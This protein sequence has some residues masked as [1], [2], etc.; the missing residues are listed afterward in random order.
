MNKLR[1][2]RR[3]SNVRR[4]QR[5]NLL[6]ISQVVQIQDSRLNQRCIVVYLT[7][8]FTLRQEDTRSEFPIYVCLAV[9]AERHELIHT[10]D[11]Q[12]NKHL[13]AVIITY[14]HRVQLVHVAVLS[15]GI[16]VTLGIIRSHAYH[17]QLYHPVFQQARYSILRRNDHL[18]IP[19]RIF[20]SLL[21]IQFRLNLTRLINLFVYLHATKDENKVFTTFRILRPHRFA[22]TQY[23]FVY[24]G[25]WRSNFVAKGNPV[26]V[27][28]FFY[29]NSVLSCH[30]LHL[31]L[32]VFA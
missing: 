2:Y 8:R 30:K 27:I 12:L 32:S 21:E 25:L 3:I 11:V 19:R 29:N 1:R 7:K 18:F 13:R 15:D 31:I 20:R 28:C 9:L 24:I 4:S 6:F 26:D 5:Y 17:L 16:V 10:E 22:L 23:Q 14:Q